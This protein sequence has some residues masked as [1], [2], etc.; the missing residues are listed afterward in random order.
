MFFYLRTKRNLYNVNK[1]INVILLSIVFYSVFSCKS[2]QEKISINTAKIKTTVLNEIDGPYV[3]DKKDSLSVLTVEQDIDSSFYIFKRMFKREK[4]HSITCYVNNSDKDSFNFKLKD[5]YNIPKAIYK[6]PEKLFVTSDIEGN[7]NAFYSMLIGNKVID[8]NYNWTFGKG[9]LVICGDMV[10]R[11]NN[12][13]PCLW[14]LYMLEQEAEKA[15]GKVHYILGNHDIM[16][17]HADLKYVKERYI[18]LAKLLSEKDDEK[19][20]W[21]ELLSDTN[22]IVKWMSSKNTI[23]RI[24]DAIY[25]HGGISVEVVDNDLTIDK[26]NEAV[27]RNIRNNLTR[28]PGDNSQ[29]NLIFSRLGPLWYRGLVKDYKEHY[30]KIDE[31]SL[32]GILEF[33]NVKKI[34]I[35]HTIVDD[36]VTSDYGGKVIRV[37]IKHIEKEKF[38]GKSEALLIEGSTYYRVNDSGEKLKLIMY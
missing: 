33:Y 35:G 5:E 22:E 6:A 15:G 31:K 21:L 37:D 14:L 17:L 9:H 3:Y 29:D 16:N 4:N 19:K 28:N 20:A 24:G 27:R 18:K 23:E 32:D 2:N 12:A 36:K 8:K 11:G 38:T 34:I 25:L 13:W 7:F 10:D 26:I 30:K 1:N